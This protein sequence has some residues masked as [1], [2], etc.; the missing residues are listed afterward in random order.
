MTT[1]RR[2][3]LLDL[4]EK[5][6]D[7]E[8][9]QRGEF[10]AGAC[11][12]DS[13]LQAEVERL[14]ALEEKAGEF[15]EVP[16]PARNGAP[17]AGV[18]PDRI[19][20]YRILKTL[21]EGGMGVVYLAEQD[22]PLRRRV[23]L[24]V[25]KL[26][27]DTREVV[28]RFESER[29]AL[30]LMDHPNIARV[31]DAGVSAEGRPYFVMEYVSG[32]PIVQFCDANRL[33]T[34]ERLVLF[35]QVCQ[36]V[37][38]AHQ[39]AIIHRD[40]KSS[41]VLVAMQDGMPLPKVID[42]GVAKATNQRLTEKT[43][44]TQQGCVIG[45]PEYMSPEQAGMM[46]VDVDTRTD[47][48]SLG[49]LL[50]E[51]LVGALPFEPSA[52]RQGGYAEMQRIIRDV[53][54]P[55]PSTRLTELAGDSAQVA[56]RRKTDVRILWRQLR[57][58]LD[59]IAMKAL[60]KDRHRRYATCS[61]FAEDVARYLRREPVAA[62]PP[63]LRY[64]LGKFVR[65]NR[66]PVAAA[67]IVFG[68][69]VAGLA[70]SLSLYFKSEENETLARSRLQ[71]VLRL[72][73]GRQLAERRAEAERL[74]PCIP[75]KVPE[76]E[77]WLAAVQTLSDRLPAHKATLEA[78]RSKAEP[79]DDRAKE[80]D[81]RTH[82]DAERLQ[83]LRENAR[84]HETEIAALRKELGE[85]AM[86]TVVFVGK[87]SERQPRD[88][89]FRHAF[90][91]Q[92]PPDRVDLAIRIAVDDSA[93]VY[94]NGVDLMSA[95]RPV[96]ATL[97]SD[98]ASRK[99]SLQEITEE[100]VCG[101][102]LAASGENAL[103]VHIRQADSAS[104][105]LY[106]SAEVA[107]GERR[108]VEAH[109]P[110]RYQSD[111]AD[112]ST[113]WRRATYDDSAWPSG[114]AP[115]GYGFTEG[116][117]RLRELE[118]MVRTLQEEIAALAEKVSAR[119]TWAFADEA[120]KWQH[121]L[122]S[123]L[124][125]D[126]E[127]FIDPDPHKGPLASVKNR[128]RVATTI[129]RE[130]IEEPAQKW[131][132]AAASIADA[133]A[134]PAYRALRIEPQVGLA[135]V[136]RD[137]RSGLWEFAHVE[138]GRP[139]ERN[140]D[141]ELVMTEETGLVF[142]LLPGGTFRMGARKPAEGERP[143]ENNIDL[144]A[145]DDEMPVHEV[146]LAPFFLSK[147]EMTQAQWLRITGSNPSNFPVGA[148]YGEKRVTPL[149]PVDS[150][151]WNA[152]HEILNRFG[153]DLP[154]E[155]QW[156]YAARGGTGTPWWTGRDRESLAGAANLLDATSRRALPPAIDQPFELWLDDGYAATAPVG[157][158]KPNPFGFHDVAGNVWEWCLDR[159]GSYKVPAAQDTGE[160][161]LTDAQDRSV[162]GGT[163]HHLA[164]GCR[165]SQRNHIAPSMSVMTG[166]RPARR[167]VR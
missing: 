82:P 92:D 132:Q 109:A 37:Q 20:A 33:S 49:V 62:S 67:G 34:E 40:I 23:A 151:T 121:D 29:Q 15:L 48:Y 64:R 143:G 138:T 44:Y 24:K 115:L 53:D 146:S 70:V 134:C 5:C 147:Y 19:G 83:R 8:P 158:Y 105:D 119:R 112:R 57:G 120:L 68:S 155:A 116:P 156:E 128:L 89:C 78:L 74:W 88:W 30:A 55:R 56:A 150:V 152:A 79:Y 54:P 96:P 136:G 22:E 106:F 86:A 4:L 99:R 137:P 142:V 122:L 25:I 139:P 110:W 26:G 113:E 84:G 3:R 50:Y 7:L 21:G 36:A 87:E 167:L 16:R 39:K 63:R 126:L 161:L 91:W 43:V 125:D 144:V 117:G 162:R 47:I 2:Q 61:E 42:F 129:R 52:L 149:H 46:D 114:P 10:L 18:Q 133:G 45:T 104:A 159:Y 107:A 166:L 80:S 163:W 103:A 17:A 85:Q 51:L 98:R 77:A 32:E 157:R 6:L 58:D 160:R 164:T 27:M 127:R 94:L 131:R 118:V 31:F 65:R 1:D 38:H 153:L 148:L 123:T 9:S 66:V 95:G 71:A 90:Q 69:L 60:E 135:P 140:P 73:D 111:T 41:N 101:A 141:G 28:A 81:R 124:V 76:L 59:W 35:K 165:S 130:T 72:S 75:E 100:R 12:G 102:A 14:L 13:S 108:L 93:V 154:T 11:A 145:M 97:G